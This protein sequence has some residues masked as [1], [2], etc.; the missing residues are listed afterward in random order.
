MHVVYLIENSIYATSFGM[1]IS[2]IRK[3]LCAPARAHIY[4]HHRIA[5]S[6]LFEHQNTDYI[7]ITTRTRI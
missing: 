2:F 3:N 6:L 1:L 7:F 5:S 4:P